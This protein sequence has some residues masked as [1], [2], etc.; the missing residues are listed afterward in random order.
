MI[1]NCT[2]FEKF[3]IAGH[4]PASNK[5]FGLFADKYNRFQN[6]PEEMGLGTGNPR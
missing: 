5:F 6:P 1:G 3:T 2:V 4:T